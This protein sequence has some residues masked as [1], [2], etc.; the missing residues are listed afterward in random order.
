MKAELS[1]NEG[2]MHIQELI[3][4]SSRYFSQ[5][6]LLY[7]KYC[8]TYDD[9][10]EEL[11]KDHEK[12]TKKMVRDRIDERFSTGYISLLDY[13]ETRFN[14]KVQELWINIKFHLSMKDKERNAYDIKITEMIEERVP[15]QRVRD[16]FNDILGKAAKLTPLKESVERPWI[17]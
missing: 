10:R 9:I 11:K 5:Y 8:R 1:R 6:I 7:S 3:W 4:S 14:N 2:R 16:V 17:P 15:P 12:V 13:Y